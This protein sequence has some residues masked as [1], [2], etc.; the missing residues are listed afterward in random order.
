MFLMRNAGCRSVEI[1]RLPHVE[2]RDSFSEPDW[3]QP[4]PPEDRKREPVFSFDAIIP[5]SPLSTYSRNNEKRVAQN[6]SAINQHNHKAIAMKEGH[7][8]SLEHVRM[9]HPTS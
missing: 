2:I 7:L 1:A 4:R 3:R 8:F 5:S 9:S 6:R